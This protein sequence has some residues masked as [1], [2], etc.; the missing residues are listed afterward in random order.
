MNSLRNSFELMYLS[1]FIILQSVE[2]P[3]YAWRNQEMVSL[4][5]SG[6][7]M[8]SSDMSGTEFYRG[9]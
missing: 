4:V 7:Y 8:A 9:H 2:H 3:V 1:R 5:S 6:K